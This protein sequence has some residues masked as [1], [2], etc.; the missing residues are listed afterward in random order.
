M[1]ARAGDPPRTMAQKITAGRGGPAQIPAQLIV[2]R[3]PT[4]A[5]AGAGAS[6][7]EIAVV[8]E[9]RSMG[10][11]TVA[12]ERVPRGV[13]I[14][15]AGAGFSGPVHLERF[16][17]PARFALSDDARAAMLGGVGMLVLVAAPADISAALARKDTP[18]PKL[19]SVQLVLSGRLRPFVSPRDVALEL[20][21]RDVRARVRAVAERTGARVVI[22]VGGPSLKLLSVPDRAVIAGVAPLVGADAILFP[23][24][25]RTASF[26]R[27]QRRSKAHRALAPDAGAPFEEV[28]T[29]DLAGV[30][31]LV[32]DE[33]GSVR[34]AAQLGGRSVR[35]VVLGGD[36]GATLR[37]LFEVAALLKSKRV[38]DD[39]DFLLAV[40]SRQ[41]L[42]VLA[43]EGALADLVATGARIV[44]P[45]VRL[46]SNEVYASPASLR[47]ADPLV[48]PPPYMV[49]SALTLA[50]AVAHGKVGDPRGFKRPPR[51]TVPRE[52]PPGD[53]LLVK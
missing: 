4:G 23:S 36:G 30:D 17:S 43:S 51:V 25:D 41:M 22:E 52:L 11:S 2:A 15:R 53:V 29:V 7:V 47:N 50:W 16:A 28:D 45:D 35:Q 13:V 21:R 24:D 14:A 31:P 20:V 27:D 9:A 5:F 3:D 26:L 1:R 32:L 10:P 48:S 33:E 44:E 39:L 38:P 18:A 46:A 8:Y 6:G 19:A 34:P 37:E 42:E 49:A 12:R 40:P